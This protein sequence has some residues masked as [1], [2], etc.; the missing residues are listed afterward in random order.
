MNKFKP[1]NLLII[2]INKK[3]N[4][5]IRIILIN[6][7][8][9]NLISKDWFF[10]KF[11][12]VN[13]NKKVNNQVIVKLIEIVQLFSLL[14]QKE[15]KAQWKI[16]VSHYEGKIIKMTKS[17][18]KYLKWKFM[19]LQTIV[20]ILINNLNLWHLG[21]FQKKKIIKRIKINLILLQIK[22]ILVSTLSK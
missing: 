2:W 5:F 7:I 13:H 14:S 12:E 15:A 19:V 10:E 8:K 9:K 11:K 22:I 21:K 20:V 16:Q 3:N 6:K 1:R 17:C 18:K 4:M